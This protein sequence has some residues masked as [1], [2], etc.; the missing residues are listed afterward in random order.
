MRPL[1]LLGGA[2]SGA[3]PFAGLG[4]GSPSASTY[5][6]GDG[7]WAPLSVSAPFQSGQK[8]TSSGTFV[9][10]VG[11]K[12]VAVALIGGGGGASQYSEPAGNGGDTSFGSYVTAP[13]GSGYANSKNSAP[14]LGS[15]LF[16]GLGMTGG[17]TNQTIDGTTYGQVG[18]NGNPG[19]PGTLVFGLCAVTP[20][21]S[22]SV[23]IGAGGS[24][25][26]GGG[27]TGGTAGV[28]V[29]RY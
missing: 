5:L 25:S 2:L 17:G 21:Q 28:A 14:N 7:V 9:V 23:T 24:P 3:P 15:S 4:T 27:V 1:G 18:T 20:G 19:S 22:I 29:V 12:T 8:F 10:P 13:G 16:A 26:G 11:V 6:R